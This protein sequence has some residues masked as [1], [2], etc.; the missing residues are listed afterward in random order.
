MQTATIPMPS[1][2][3]GR[4]PKYC[5]VGGNP[6]RCYTGTTSFTGLRV[7]GT[8]SSIKTAQKMYNLCY[9]ECGGLLLVIDM[10]TG[11]VANV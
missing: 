5:V 1:K 4:H 7:V 2:K 3:Q 9:E 10:E 6:F 11:M 8:T